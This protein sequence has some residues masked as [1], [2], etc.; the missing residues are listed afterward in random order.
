MAFADTINEKMRLDFSNVVESVIE[1]DMS[2][3]GADN[4]N[5]FLNIVIQNYAITP[6]Y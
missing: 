1:S 6:L 4:R 5:D 2:V 3:F